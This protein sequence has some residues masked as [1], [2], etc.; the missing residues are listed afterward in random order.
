V[1]LSALRFCFL[2]QISK[3]PCSGQQLSVNAAPMMCSPVKTKLTAYRGKL[4]EVTEQLGEKPN[5]T[6]FAITLRPTPSLNQTNLVIGKV[7]YC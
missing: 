4:V 5:G 6:A 1:M 3:P 2:L 7:H